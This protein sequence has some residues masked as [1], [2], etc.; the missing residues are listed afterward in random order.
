[1]EHVYWRYV[2]A[3]DVKGYRSLW[4]TNFVGWPA[5]SAHPVH[6]DHITDWM[7]RPVSEGRRVKSY[8]LKFAAGQSFGKNLVVDYYWATTVWTG[9]NGDLP[10][11]TLRMM[12]TWMRAGDRWQI[13]DGMAAEVPNPEP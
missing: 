12:H 3:L 6:K 8:Q 7:K 4:N 1:M 13:I 11:D 9:K 5:G 2:K 10:P